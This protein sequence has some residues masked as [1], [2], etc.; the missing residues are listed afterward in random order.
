MMTCSA[1]PD[2]A[3]IERRHATGIGLLVDGGSSRG[4]LLSGE[5]EDV[6]LTVSRMDAEKKSNPGLSGVPRQRRQR[7]AHARPVRAGRSSSSGRRPRGRSGATCGRAATAAA[8]T[9]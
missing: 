8:S 4:N 3:E 1:P 9:R 2:C 7:D 5:A 6:I